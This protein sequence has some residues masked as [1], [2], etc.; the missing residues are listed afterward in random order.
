MRRR[1]LLAAPALLALPVAAQE[2]Y[3]SR[4]VR[5]IVPFA[6]GGS[7]DVLARLSA[8]LLTER[9]GQNVVVENI[10]GAGGTLGAARVAEAPPDGYTLMAGTPG[11][12]T[13]TPYL[14]ARLPY[15]PM[16]DLEPV[17]FV[18]DSPGVLVVH[19]SSRLTSVAAVLAEARA[20][21][22]TLTYASAGVGSFGHLAG[23][24]FRWKT[25][26]ELV[27]VPYRGTTP[28]VTD[29]LAGRAELMF[30]N[31]PSVQPWITTG[32]L[33]V[34]G[35]GLPRRFSLLPDAPTMIEAGVPE[36]KASSWFGLFTRAG[37]PRPVVEAVN[38]AMNDG[39]RT[40][41]MLARLRELGVEATGG[42]PEAF[43]ALM[44]QRYREIGELVRA[45]RITLQ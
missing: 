19:K 29:V 39:L 21:P 27:H 31:F 18:G 15:D 33:R 43:R 1:S 28:G 10:T 16:R 24:L 32:E 17:V 20:K 2:R 7:T 14:M 12:V 25:G 38:R 34:L 40:P 4:P 30:D 37:T 36:F 41:A 22:G 23:E 11:P 6:T 35:V 45:A 44:Q 5:M 9:L 42:T 3:P 26:A 13:I 8:Q